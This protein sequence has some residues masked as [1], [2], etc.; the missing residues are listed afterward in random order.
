MATTTINNITLDY[1]DQPCMI[2]NPCPIEVT[3]T[4]AAIEVYIN[5]GGIAYA[6]K[7]DTPNG[8]VIDVQD[9]LQS[10]FDNLNLGDD[11]DYSQPVTLSELGKTVNFTVRALDT[12][13]TVLAQFNLSIFC[14][15][16]ALK[17][18]EEYFINSRRIKR[19][20]N[21]PLTVGVYGSYISGGT[22]NVIDT[23]DLNNTE[24][25]SVNSMGV[26]NTLVDLV[27]TGKT[28][29]VEYVYIR[30]GQ[31]VHQLRYIIECVDTC[32]RDAVYLRWIDRTGVWC[33]WLFKMGNDSR[34]AEGKGL[35]HR[36]DLYLY[37]RRWQ[38]HGNSGRRQ[39]YSRQDVL[40]VCAPLV[41]T[42]T[43]EFLQDATTSPAV[44]MYLGKDGGVHRWAP[45][46]IEPGT[47][48]RD[49]KKREQ[50]FIMNIVLPETIIQQL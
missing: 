2:F 15:W 45:V 31:P 27:P 39:N 50:D 29:E 30:M 42:E 19:F 8:G 24:S 41:D 43:F 20:G 47:Y 14:V 6:F 13:D 3:G 12:D 5:T 23:D 1:P 9:Y 7:F 17:P 25:T 44:D 18:G 4:L 33:Y 35:F 48:T 38:W 16:G 49:I 46:T 22:I 28:I 32:F 26:Y 21:Y 34:S 10:F 11:I 37:D 40:P 36:N